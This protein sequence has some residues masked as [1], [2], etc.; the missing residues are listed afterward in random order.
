ML[1]NLRSILCG[2]RGHPTGCQVW[3]FF[4]GVTILKIT[5]FVLA[6]SQGF[7]RPFVG[8][9][10]R[11]FYIPAAQHIIQS[12]QYNDRQT[13][14][15]SSMAPAYSYLLAGLLKATADNYLEI[16]VVI[17]MIL[18]CLTA[19]LIVW[20][21]RLISAPGVGAVAG[22]LWLLYPPEVLISTWITPEPL[23]TVLLVLSV[24]LL[25]V[26]VKKNNTR[27]A[28]VSGLIMGV[29]ALT[30]A[31]S[32]L[33]APYW[34][35]L[36]MMRRGRRLWKLALVVVVGV[37]LAVL[38]WTLRNALVLQDLILI[39]TGTGYVFWQGSL[40]ELWD[41][42]G[43][44]SETAQSTFDEAEAEGIVKPTDQKMSS[45]DRWKLRV[46]LRNYRLR[47]E[48]RPLS[49]IPF[50][51]QKFF[52]LWYGIESANRLKQIGL[53]FFSLLVVPMGALQIIRWRKS[54]PHVFWVV[55]PLCIYFVLLHWITL[56]TVRYMIPVYPLFL[57]GS[58][59]W[60]MSRFTNVSPTD[61][62]LKSYTC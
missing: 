36:V 21:G 13:R 39:Q 27:F 29:A 33:F 56:P 30:R 5:L 1:Q 45:L 60:V 25:V 58:V 10:A 62:H 24:T 14:G 43:K 2:K 37:L 11:A 4:G 46:G 9:N 26:S 54:A 20:L 19:V 15:F 44:V 53:G 48:E 40:E 6:V 52:R 38:P 18:D 12:G 34:G 50:A 55:A 35:I 7:A 59:Q 28:L 32:L 31:A 51:A 23:Y 61:V 3:L 47:L 16:A 42:K 22:F 8:G 41:L 49:F 17:Q 57:L